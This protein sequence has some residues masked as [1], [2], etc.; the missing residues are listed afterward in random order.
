MCHSNTQ[1]MKKEHCEV[2][3]HVGSDGSSSEEVL[4][5]ESCPALVTAVLLKFRHVMVSTESRLSLSFCLILL[6]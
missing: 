5:C 6:L 2:Q 1:E 4:T 3:K